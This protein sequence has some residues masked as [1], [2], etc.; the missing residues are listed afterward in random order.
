MAPK[1][2]IVVLNWNGWEY[3]LECLESLCRCTCP[4]CRIVVIDNG[5]TDDS[6]TRIRE[7]ADGKRTAPARFT[8]G[9]MIAKP[10]PITSYTKEMAERG[11][12]PA[13]EQRM[14]S[15]C[16]RSLV[17]IQTGAN[18]GFAGGNNVGIRYACTRDAEYILLLNNDA[19]FRSP[20]TLSTM[21]EFMER[22]PRAAACGGRLFYPDGSPQQSYGNFPA[23]LRILAYLFP[24]YRLLPQ[25]WLKR[26]KRSN[27][28]PDGTDQKPLR[29]DWPSGAC[30]LVRAKA[31]EDVGL[32]DEQYFLYVEETD[33]CFR[34]HG[35]GWDR[36]YLPQAEVIHAFGGSVSGA[37]VSMQRYHLESQFT[38]YRKHFSSQTLAVVATG[39]MLRSPFSALYWK[40]AALVLS[41]S[42]RIKALENVAYWLLAFSLAM[43][44]M[45]GI[46]SGDS[47]SNKQHSTAI[48][49]RSKRPA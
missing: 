47:V 13:E 12:S 42:P 6:E 38:Y 2:F 24:W 25:R 3:T 35:K 15:F 16:T 46:V 48:G 21:I 4:N 7:W 26:A 49:P 22:T 5:S 17:M 41:G 43:T 29:I 18:L 34:M 19:Y 11:G 33:W 40:V 37:P 44:A 9:D 28:I 10:L 30:L 8:H 27:V 39:Y 36:Y 23:V 32:L 31:L 14:A 20:E 45:R 1:T